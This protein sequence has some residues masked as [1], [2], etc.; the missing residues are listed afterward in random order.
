MD[1][2]MEG[3]DAGY[4]DCEYDNDI[5][6]DDDEDTPTTATPWKIF[7]K[8]WNIF[9]KFITLIIFIIYYMY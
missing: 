9:S 5:D 7:I 4:D 3:Y 2:W 8:L 6:S 1:Q